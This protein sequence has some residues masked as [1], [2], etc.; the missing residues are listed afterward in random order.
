MSKFALLTKIKFATLGAAA[1]MLM[2][3]QAFAVDCDAS[4]FQVLA[5]L[6]AD[7]LSAND[8]QSG[9][10]KKKDIDAAVTNW[11]F[12]DW[13]L[14]G[15]FEYDT[16]TETGSLSATTG[17]SGNYFWEFDS[18]ALSNFEDAMFVVKQGSDKQSEN[19]SAYYF[20]GLGNNSGRFQPDEDF[21]GDEYSYVRMYTRGEAHS[22][23][24]IDAASGGIAM[25]LLIGLLTVVRERKRSRS[26]T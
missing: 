26:L 9:S 3:T 6:S 1:S 14:A 15:T 17:T 7:Y 16:G 18:A 24:E 21:V 11:L 22:V 20:A 23:P 5:P 10:N 25:A 2:S 13:S 4:D 8:C 19:W 12:N